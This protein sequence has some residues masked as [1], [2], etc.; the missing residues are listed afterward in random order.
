MAN[1]QHKT[2]QFDLVSPEAILFSAPVSMAV[3]P[4]TEGDMGVGP[5][6]ASLVVTLGNGLVQ[7]HSEDGKEIKKVFIAGGFA[8]VGGNSCRVLAEQAVNFE[9]LDRK[10][11]E[12]QLKDLKEDLSMAEEPADEGRIHTQI[13]ITEAKLYALA[14]SS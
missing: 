8:D 4:A 1:T 14:H 7:L 3:I 11:L 13:A 12:Q 9:D 10:A 5:D 6:H 2:M